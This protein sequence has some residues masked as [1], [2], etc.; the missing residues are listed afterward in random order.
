MKGQPDNDNRAEGDRR[1]RPDAAF[2]QHAEVSACLRL[3]VILRV[4]ETS[5]PWPK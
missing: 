1:A 2:E 5:L 4:R 3:R